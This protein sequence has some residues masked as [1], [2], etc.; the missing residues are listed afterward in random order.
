MRSHLRTLRVVVLAAASM[1]GLVGAHVLDYAVIFRN[2]AA[3]ATVLLN[4]GHAYFGRAVEFGIVSAVLA[5]IGA[6]AVGAFGGEQPGERW[7]KARVATVL[8]LIQSGGFVALEAGE[9]VAA[10]ALAERFIEVTVIG[11][12]LQVVVATVTTFVLGLLERAGDL[13]ARALAGRP[14][15]VPVARI[16]LFPRATRRPRS[17]H[18]FRAAPRAPPF[19]FAS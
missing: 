5:A 7:S 14:A 6:V 9:R 11:I 15:V 19:S 8:A 2:P 4:T 17:L 13:V 1:A 3:R 10:H 18:L 12:A 16:A